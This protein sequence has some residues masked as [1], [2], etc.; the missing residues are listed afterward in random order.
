MRICLRSD[1]NQE[2]NETRFIGATKSFNINNFVCIVWSGS[3][4]NLLENTLATGK[5][6]CGKRNLKN[7]SIWDQVLNEHGHIITLEYAYLRDAAL[8][9]FTVEIWD[10]LKLIPAFV[11]GWMI[12]IST[13]LS[14]KLERML[15]AVVKLMLCSRV[16]INVLRNRYAEKERGRERERMRED[17]KGRDRKRK[18]EGGK[19]KSKKERG[20]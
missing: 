16:P 15:R 14:H 7:S 17:V 18:K 13:E 1:K 5:N 12:T 9:S 6:K 19:E 3:L 4:R 20:R 2:T 10:H 11:L 8:F